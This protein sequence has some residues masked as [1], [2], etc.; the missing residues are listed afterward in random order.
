MPIVGIQELIASAKPERVTVFNGSA[1]RSHRRLL[2]PVQ[3]WFEAI[4]ARSIQATSDPGLK[5]S[6]FEAFRREIVQAVENIR[7]NFRK[8]CRETW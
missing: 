1:H 7:N 8:L 5:Q 3:H 2:R 4:R 6:R